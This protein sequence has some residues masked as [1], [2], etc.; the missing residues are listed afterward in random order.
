MEDFTLKVG[1]RHG[2]GHGV[3]K[4][5]KGV[6]DEARRCIMFIDNVVLVDKNKNV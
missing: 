1:V 5:T 4:L 2:R 6:Q 3:R